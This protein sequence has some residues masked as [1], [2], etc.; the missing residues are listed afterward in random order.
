M[1]CDKLKES[2]AEQVT[3][4]CVDDDKL[5]SQMFHQTRAPWCRTYLWVFKTLGAHWYYGG[6]HILMICSDS[7]PLHK[8]IISAP[9]VMCGE[10]HQ[11]SPILKSPSPIRTWSSSAIWPPRTTMAPKSWTTWPLSQSHSKSWPTR[12]TSMTTPESWILPAHLGKPENETVN[13]KWIEHHQ[14]GRLSKIRPVLSAWKNPAV[15]LF[16]GRN[17]ESGNM[18]LCT[19]ILEHSKLLLSCSAHRRNWQRVHA[20]PDLREWPPSRKPW[21]CAV[22]GISTTSSDQGSPESKQMAEE[23]STT[24]SSKTHALIRTSR[25]PLAGLTNGIAERMVQ[26]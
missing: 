8:V 18:E 16:I 5:S 9:V 3:K 14:T 12:V 13:P 11:R 2:D 26:Q 10:R 21:H 1:A 20:A 17:T 24:S 22:T 7:H 6:H 19:W 15:E 23:N 4:Y 25:W